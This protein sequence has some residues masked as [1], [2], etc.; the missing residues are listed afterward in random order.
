MTPDFSQAKW[1]KSTRSQQ[2]T[3]QCV[4]VAAVP[5]HVGVRDS[6]DPAGPHLVLT[7]EEWRSFTHRVKLRASV[8][9]T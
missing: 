3:D 6:R 7:S 2:T 1:T 8:K 5:G 9:I 4:E